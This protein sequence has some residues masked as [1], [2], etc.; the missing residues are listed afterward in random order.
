MAESQKKPAPQPVEYQQTQEQGPVGA[1]ITSPILWGGLI[2]IGFYSALPH[3][4]AQRELAVRYFCSHPLEYVTT[5]LFFMGV[6]TLLIKGLRLS[7]EKRALRTVSLSARTILKTNDPLR[8]A[9]LIQDDLDH[10]GSSLQNTELVRRLRDVC[11]HI[12]GR[13]S[14]DNLSEH[15]QYLAELAAERLHGSYAMVRTV[16]WA[17][18]I[19]GFLGTVIGITMAIANVTPEQLD[20]SLGEVTGGLA[21]AFDT[22]ALALG[23]SLVLVFCT[24]V[25]ERSEQKV[26]NSVEEF[27]HKHLASLFPSHRARQQNR[28]IDAEGKVA[29]K[30]LN[31]TEKM[32]ENQLQL[33][34]QSLESLRTRWTESL[35]GQ[36]AEFDDMVRRGMQATLISHADQLSEARGEFLDAFQNASQQL[37]DQAARLEEDRRDQLTDFSQ[38]LDGVWTRIRH[39]MKEDQQEQSGMLA[40]TVQQ[41]TTSIS[42]WQTQLQVSTSA[43]RTQ[44]D[45][46]QKQSELLLQLSSQQDQ[47]VNIQSQLA[48]NLETVRA[49]E[50][51]QETLHSLNA[52]IHLL[53]ARVRPHAA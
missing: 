32:I 24:F 51:L 30:M 6:T 16:T 23:L 25:A 31:Q 18:P 9:A 7:A 52:V 44:L 41:L 21:V 35:T 53:T 15:L 46:I 4:P 43:G 1:V 2:T 36:K 47:L 38:K 34:Q 14:A 5:T 39:D 29:E 49:A 10:S 20:T 48:T 11:T 28:L 50:S 40:S 12:T 42:D 8:K 45:E 13:R 27:G 26:L 33:W 3:L 22:T 19:L 17:V 37:A